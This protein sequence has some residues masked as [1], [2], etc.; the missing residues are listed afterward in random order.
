MT[1]RWP[2]LWPERMSR[3]RIALIALIVIVALQVLA[4][5]LFSVQRAKDTE[6]QF[7]FPLP[8][9]AAAIAELLEAAPPEQ[10]AVALRA[11][12]SPDVRVLVLPPD[13]AIAETPIRNFPSVERAIRRYSE[14]LQ[15]REIAVYLAP[16]DPDADVR[17]TLRDRGLWSPYPLRLDIRLADGRIARIETRGDLARRIFGWPIGLGAGIFGLLVAAVA[18]WSVWRETRPLIG[19]AGK[20]DRF[21]DAVEPAPVP[22]TGPMEVRT[23]IAAFNRLQTRIAGLL[24]ARNTMLGAVSHDLRTFLTRLR[25]RTDFIADDA[26]RTKAEA[27]LD[28]MDRMIGSALALA[29]SEAGSL[30]KTRF[31]LAA[32]VDE[33]AEH[34]EAELR[35]PEGPVFVEGDRAALAR[36]FD[37]LLE[38]ARKYA[39]GFEVA[40]AA[41]DGWAVVEV[42]DR[43]PGLGETDLERLT[44]PF[45]RGDR[46]RTQSASGEPISGSG[47][48]LAIARN[49]LEVHGGRL[50]LENR[51]G[52]GL[53]ARAL[54]P[55][56][57]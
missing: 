35:R 51:V 36:V 39:G 25:L 32:L 48:G 21:A 56:A 9:Q 52:G 26:Q 12:N 15:N 23:L 53:T 19:L 37:N 13:A 16:E 30:E 44:R 5:T 11:V 55:V 14:A 20:L 22:E 38:N 18:A 33:L 2:K 1:L 50:D 54:I 31:D 42:L 40:L 47:L 28:A 45:E 49:L 43:G 46:A 29:R 6:G 27:D 4:A 7:R 3:L 34:R 10:E 8:D 24:E 41:R 57:D 17:L